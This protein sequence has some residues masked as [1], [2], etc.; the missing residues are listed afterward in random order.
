MEASVIVPCRNGAAT[1]AEALESIARQESDRP[2]ELILIDNASTD[3]SGAV[4]RAFAARH[5]GL[6][7][8]LIDASDRPGKARALN[9]AIPQARGRAI[10]LVDADDAVAPGWLAAMAAALDESDLVAAATDYRPLNEDWVIEYRFRDPAHRERLQETYRFHY[11]T[12]PY[13][14]GHCMGFTRRLFDALGGFDETYAVGDDV[15]FSLRAQLQGA[16][17]RPVP[18]AVVHYRLRATL[19]GIRRQAHLYAIDQVRLS[20]RFPEIA[21]PMP[22][23]WR[24]FG[25]ETRLLVRQI[26][27]FLLDRA[28]RSRV[29]TARLLWSLGWYTGLLRGMI[30]F[31]APPP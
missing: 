14:S 23:R 20:E 10:L 21:R 4:F 15:D 3:G 8:R 19:P 11:R 29:Q 9:L 16:T 25:R 7:A 24:S 13:V 1:L 2:W 28:W 22:V 12:L 6:E 27:R 31:R 26:G 5:P 30:T 18:D 17:I